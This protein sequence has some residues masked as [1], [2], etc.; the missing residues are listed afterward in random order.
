M[1]LVI[2][3]LSSLLLCSSIEAQTR[4]GNGWIA[5]T[6]LHL[7]NGATFSISEVNVQNG[8]VHH[9]S[10]RADV[11]D[12]HVD[13]AF[14]CADS[15]VTYSHRNGAPPTTDK[16]DLH[17]Y[18]GLVGILKTVCAQKIYPSREEACE[19]SG[20]ATMECHAQEERGTTANCDQG[21]AQAN[22]KKNQALLDHNAKMAQH[23]QDLIDRLTAQKEKTGNCLG[24]SPN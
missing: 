13:L 22:A 15:T 23:Y 1:R 6:T 9:F 2:G 24:V 16:L 4:A 21:I 19:G 20:T 14:S 10:G 12:E 7:S 5:P 11:K 18:G 8:M 3:V 17:L